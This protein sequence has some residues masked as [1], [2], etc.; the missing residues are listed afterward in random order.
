LMDVAA[1]ARNKSC[2]LVTCDL[3][4]DTLRTTV[5]AHVP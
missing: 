2:V 3:D 5:P 1:I 4:T